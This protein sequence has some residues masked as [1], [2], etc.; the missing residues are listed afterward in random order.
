M[1]NYL[2]E[3]FFGLLFGIVAFVYFSYQGLAREKIESEED[4]VLVHGSF[5]NY[6]F[7]DNTGYRRQGHQYYI[8]IDSYRNAFQIK[9]DYLGIFKGVEFMTTVRQGDIIQFTI[10]KF[11]TI[12]LNSDKN[13][14]V[15]SIKVKRSTYLS[16]S[17]TLEI[18]RGL[19]TSYADF[20]LA[21]GFL[22]VGLVV[23]L[24]KR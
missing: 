18:E 6:S 15:T 4:L 24:R 19:A 14:F 11:Q 9:A 22:I 5:M 2:N 12:K 17:E 20:F 3:G 7:K 10:P 8:W 16:K 23:Y 21:G 13:V 1:K